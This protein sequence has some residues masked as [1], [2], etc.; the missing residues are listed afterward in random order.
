MVKGE[1]KCEFPH[2]GEFKYFMISPGNRYDVDKLLAKIS[3][4]DRG[5]SEQNPDDRALLDEM[6]WG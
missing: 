5:C 6:N 4:I 3:R 2:D 1:F